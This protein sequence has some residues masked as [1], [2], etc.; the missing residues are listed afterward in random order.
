MTAPPAQN[1]DEVSDERVA[2]A[3]HMM[4]DYFQ[5]TTVISQRC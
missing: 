5:Q 3:L 2:N 1:Q 4:Q